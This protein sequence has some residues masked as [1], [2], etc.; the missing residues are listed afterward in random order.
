MCGV[1]DLK[2]LEGFSSGTGLVLAKRCL[3]VDVLDK[4]QNMY[5]YY[6]FV[7]VLL[8]QIYIMFKC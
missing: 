7:Q 4:G 1:M 8:T 3:P 2:I 6:F 5:W